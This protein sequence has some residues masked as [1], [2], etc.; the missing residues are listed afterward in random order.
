MK[1]VIA[2]IGFFVLII[3]VLLIALPFIYVP[4]TVI[5]AYQVPQSTVLVDGSFPHFTYAP[6]HEVTEGDLILNAGDSL[7]IQVNVT[8]GIEIN[9][10]V[11]NGSATV[12]SYYDF[13]T[14]NV[15]W[16]VPSKFIFGI[17]LPDYLIVR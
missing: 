11:N 10:S 17:K 3:G 2:G 1:K 9:L 4:K 14:L 8:S 5:Q 6:V 12:L 13:T 7:N 16:T 15:N